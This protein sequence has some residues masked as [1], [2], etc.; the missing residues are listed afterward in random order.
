MSPI[1]KGGLGRGLGALLSD[2][3]EE[4][5]ISSSESSEMLLAN[6][7]PNIDQP[8]KQFNK[9]SLSALVESIKRHGIITPL[10]DTPME[11]G[12]YMI[13]AGERRYRAAKAAGLTPVRTPS[14]ATGRRR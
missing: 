8:R 12:K 5:V 1:R 7:E 11:N 6:I 10:I 9:E 2:I 14:S 4:S 3:E 13:I